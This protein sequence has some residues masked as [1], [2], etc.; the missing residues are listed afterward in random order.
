MKSL[1]GQNSAG[2]AYYVPE[3]YLSEPNKQHQAD[4]KQ[5]DRRCFAR[6]LLEDTIKTGIHFN[7]YEIMMIG[8]R[9]IDGQMHEVCMPM[10][11]RRRYR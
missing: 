5:A 6:K 2:M 1:P 10:L 3:K 4:G 9:G 7:Y 8:M 11:S